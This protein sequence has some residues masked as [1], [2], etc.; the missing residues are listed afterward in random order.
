MKTKKTAIA[1][2]LMCTVL[3]S[4]AQILN[5]T[6]VNKWDP[7]DPLALTP[8][9]YLIPAFICLGASTIILIF[10][11]KDG[12]LSTV[13]PI[14]AM[15]YVWVVVLSPIFFPADTLNLLKIC[16]VI[17]IVCGVSLLGWSSQ[18]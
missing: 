5:K 14:I 15:T 16:G 2:V 11:L 10:A 13:Y 17:T 7:Q 6:G 18:K 4:A 1:L 12:E 3:G 8:L 9:F